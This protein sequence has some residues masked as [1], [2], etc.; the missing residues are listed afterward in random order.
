MPTNVLSYIAHHEDLSSKRIKFLLPWARYAV[1]LSLLRV[2]ILLSLNLE[3]NC[4]RVDAPVQL[5]LH[6][7]QKIHSLLCHAMTS[8]ISCLFLPGLTMYQY[9][10]RHTFG[11][12]QSKLF[13][14]YFML[15]LILSTVTVV[16]FIIENPLA[17][18]G[19]QEKVQV[20]VYY[21][22]VH[23]VLL[24]FLKQKL[25]QC[26]LVSLTLRHTRGGRNF[27]RCYVCKGGE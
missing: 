24:L 4:H 20:S 3:L 23:V 21:Y 2:N 16:T 19:Y 7:C 5:C 22:Y 26:V 14:K 25:L 11:Y 27:C 9:L 1:I 17:T 18:W 13:P 8:S 6:V 15:G 10:P 12:I